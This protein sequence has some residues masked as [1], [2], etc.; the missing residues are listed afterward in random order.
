MKSGAN[1]EGEN[2]A[3]KL[4]FNLATFG[5]RNKGNNPL[6]YLHNRNC[7]NKWRSTE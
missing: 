4:D 3:R 1:D 6:K 7:E 5:E 2:I